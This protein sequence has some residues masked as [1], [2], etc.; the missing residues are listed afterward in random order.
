MEGKFQGSQ[1]SFLYFFGLIK[2]I[3]LIFLKIKDDMLKFIL[4]P[5]IFNYDDYMFYFYLFLASTLKKT[6]TFK[7]AGLRLRDCDAVPDFID[8]SL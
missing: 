5:E 2:D 1:T 3:G 7:D 8:R 4:I 6:P